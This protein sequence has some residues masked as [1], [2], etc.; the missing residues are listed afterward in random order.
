M[1]QSGRDWDISEGAEVFTVDGDRLGRVIRVEEG[2]L[3]VEEG[4]LFPTGHI[5]PLRAIETVTGGAVHLYVTR[6]VVLERTWDTALPP[7]EA[8]TSSG[9]DDVEI[10]G[11]LPVVEGGEEILRVPV[12]EEELVPTTEERQIGEVVFNKNVVVEDRVVDVPVVEERLRITRHP[13]D[14]EPD[15][16]DEVFTEGSLT[17]PIRGDEVG[18]TKRAR[19]AEEIEIAKEAV[20]MTEQ[21]T[22]TV[23]REQVHVDSV[24]RPVETTAAR[25]DD[26]A[27]A[28][29]MSSMPVVTDADE[30]VEAVEPSVNNDA[31][32][33]VD[34]MDV[35]DTSATAE[36]SSLRTA[37]SPRSANRSKR[38]KP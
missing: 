28:A 12:H 19:V 31:V 11:A 38:K 23:R 26:D 4:R 25:L 24:E 15:A 37:R 21:V 2:H 34:P 29:E 1:A 6:D 35:P 5:I 18:L 3:V 10:L 20:Q 9:S 16:D 8:E 33:T 17:I 22:G 32:Q 27:P 7:L 30:T 13:V 36:T 14:R